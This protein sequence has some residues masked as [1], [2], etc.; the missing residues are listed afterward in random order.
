MTAKQLI[1][2]I[3]ESDFSTPQSHAS[4]CALICGLWNSDKCVRRQDLAPAPPL[5]ILDLETGEIRAVS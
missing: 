5:R 4:K 3:L 2:K 1:G